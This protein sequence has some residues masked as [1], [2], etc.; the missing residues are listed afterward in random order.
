[1]EPCVERASGEFLGTRG[2]MCVSSTVT[3]M[4]FVSQWYLFQFLWRLRGALAA[5]ENEHA[6]Y[7]HNK[8]GLV[9]IQNVT[10]ERVGRTCVQS[11]N[12]NI[13]SS[14]ATA[15]TNSPGLG[16]LLIEYCQ[17]VDQ[18]IGCEDDH[19]GGSGYTVNGRHWGPVRIRGNKYRAGYDAEL[20]Q[21]IWNKTHDKSF[22]PYNGAL[23][24]SRGQACERSVYV[25]V[26]DNGKMLYESVSADLC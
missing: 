21:A 10:M 12:R 22:P 20:T 3:F 7:L 17:C 26:V 16:A 25:K 5:A 15:S 4:I 9:L 23:V 18:G 1:M 13:E 19:H 24:V 2:A 8:K 14:A 6:F 11:V